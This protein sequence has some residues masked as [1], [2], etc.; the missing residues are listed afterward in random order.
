MIRKLV[1]FI[2]FFIALVSAAASLC[3]CSGTRKIKNTVQAKADIKTEKNVDSANIKKVDSTAK[4][5]NEKSSVTDTDISQSKTTTDTS[6]ETIEVNLQP[7][8]TSKGTPAN[9]YAGA[10]KVYDVQINGN[11]IHS[12]Q[13]I[14]NVVLHNAKGNKTVEASSIKIKDSSQQKSNTAT[15]VTKL[16]SGHIVV[17][18]KSHAVV[19]T[20][21]K[22]LN[23]KRF[24]MG[25]GFWLWLSIGVVGI[26][27]S[28]RMGWLG[29][30]TAFFKR[31][32]D[33]SNTT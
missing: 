2:L 22:K 10:P 26:A 32:K 25:F 20:K 12:S 3:S 19:E 9:D 7:V 17:A 13:P 21:T 14:K 24:G 4:A 31:K 6:S 28:W 33:N 11:T 30:L 27:V 18:E 1:L 23:I 8:D 5:S 29:W 15:S 16:D